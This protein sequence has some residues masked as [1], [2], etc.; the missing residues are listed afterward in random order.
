MKEFM[1]K[2]AMERSARKSRCVSLLRVVLFVP[3]LLL[4]PQL[5][6]FNLSVSAQ[7]PTGDYSKFPHANPMH[8]RLPCLLCH[9]REGTSVRPA[10]PG[11]NNH[12][13]CVGCHSQQFANSENPVCTICHTDVK[14]GAL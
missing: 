4:T 5:L 11:G 7:W 6:G 9:R 8:A 2:I 1:A 10:M 14:S 13:P 12:T 3:L